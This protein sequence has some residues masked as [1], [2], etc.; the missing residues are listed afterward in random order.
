MYK[1]QTTDQSCA[2]DQQ[3][4]ATSPC[5]KSSARLYMEIIFTGGTPCATKSTVRHGRYYSLSINKVNSVLITWKKREDNELQKVSKCD[6]V[7]HDN[8]NIL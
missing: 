5:L 6:Q 1:F 3:L 8:T 2:L 4:R 7:I